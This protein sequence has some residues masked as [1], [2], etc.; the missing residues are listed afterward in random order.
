VKN[1]YINILLFHMK[2]TYY[3]HGTIFLS[4]TIKRCRLPFA[5]DSVRNIKRKLF[6]QTHQGFIHEAYREILN[7]CPNR[8]NFRI[9]VNTP[10]LSTK[11]LNGS[12]SMK[13]KFV[14]INNKQIFFTNPSCLV[15]CPGQNNRKAP[16]SF[17]HGCCK[18]R[19]K[20]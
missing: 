9:V 20:N 7:V 1:T 3:S 12:R 15:W 18:R 5:V 10:F 8:N 4:M 13:G 17:F 6:S 19:L 14:A 16:L 11:L 2:K